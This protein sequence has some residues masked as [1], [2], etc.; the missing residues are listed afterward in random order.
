MY[1][2]AVGAV[3]VRVNVAIVCMAEP[4]GRSSQAGQSVVMLYK[5]TGAAFRKVDMSPD[6][7]SPPPL[8]V[9]ARPHRPVP[10]TLWRLKHA[11]R[12]SGSEFHTK[13]D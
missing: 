9:L 7:P 4:V 12:L 10:T 6:A 5:C 11:A 13:L 2:A 1:R 8:H 3:G